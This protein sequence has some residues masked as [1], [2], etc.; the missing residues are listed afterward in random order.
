MELSPLAQERLA[1]IG[2]LSEEE[3][4]RLKYSVG[5]SYL[6]ADFF[7]GRL[8]ADGLWKELKKH[9]DEGRAFMLRDA[10]RKI[11][12]AMQLSTR[13]R[14]ME[15]LVRGLLAAESL[16]D[17]PNYSALEH[18]LKALDELRSRYRKE[19]TRTLEK[20]KGPGGHAGAPARG[21]ET[22]G[23]VSGDGHCGAAGSGDVPEG[24]SPL[25]RLETIYEQKFKEQ[26]RRISSLI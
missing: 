4:T 8:N 17:S 7:T 16:K 18:E 9:K 21:M 13:D 2:E 3:K 15:K 24:G 20:L 5:L 10:Q 14:E 25:F 12:D 22:A 26:V 1:R 11:L 6:L 23:A 19:R